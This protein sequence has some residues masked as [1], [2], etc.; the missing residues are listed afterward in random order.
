MELYPSL[1][2]PH[3]KLIDCNIKEEYGALEYTNIDEAIE[4]A[5]KIGCGAILIK[6]D[7]ADAF[8]HI[9]VAE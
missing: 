6:K 8:C 2:H 5:I 1:S 9:P 4:L 7:L 3:G